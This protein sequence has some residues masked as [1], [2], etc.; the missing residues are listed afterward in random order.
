MLRGYAT[1]VGESEDEVS[2]VAVPIRRHDGTA[3]ASL[4]VGAPPS[5]L[6][7][8]DAPQ[9]ADAL[10]AAAARISELLP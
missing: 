2:S 1:S 4:A 9:V 10:H 7:E 8:S 6:A 5:R 3:V